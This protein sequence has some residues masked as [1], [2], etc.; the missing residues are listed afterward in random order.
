VR[1]AV[2]ILTLVLILAGVVMVWRS[3]DVTP[4]GLLIVFGLTINVIMAAARHWR[5]STGTGKR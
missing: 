2:S 5:P 1:I 4:G 3:G